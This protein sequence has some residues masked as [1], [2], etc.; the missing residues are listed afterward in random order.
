MEEKQREIE[1]KFL[2]RNARNSLKIK[3]NILYINFVMYN[4]FFYTY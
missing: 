1:K 3:K 2:M 4:M